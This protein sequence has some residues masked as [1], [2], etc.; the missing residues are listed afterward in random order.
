MRHI[1]CDLETLGQTPG[2]VILS[3]GAVEF[4]PSGKCALDDG[5]YTV[6][7]TDDCC[8]HYLHIDAEGPDSTVAWWEKQGE[9]ARKVLFAARDTK[10]SV[11]LKLGLEQLNK[12]VT[13]FGGVK[14]VC[15]W[16]NGS[17]FD[18]AIL[19]VAYRMADMKPSWHFTN[20]RCYR[21]LKNICP[22]PKVARAGTYHHALD[23]AK[24][25]ALHAIQLIKA[26]PGLAF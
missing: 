25:Q 11:P 12:Y 6:L 23:D 21:T 15:V 10:T 7:N 22:G 3:I 24:T 2:C 13:R 19:A 18:N 1:M 17:D 16:G 5:M 8:D 26:Y 20:N 9:E 14:D 4:D